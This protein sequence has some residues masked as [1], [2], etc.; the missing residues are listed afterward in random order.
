MEGIDVESITVKDLKITRRDEGYSRGREGYEQILHASL[1]LLVDEG[2]KA[3][4]FRRI[5]KACDMNVGNVTYYFKTKEDLI[6]QLLDAII[7][8]Y[9]DEFLKIM[10]LT[11]RGPERQLE[12]YVTVIINDIATRKTTRV[13]PELW[14]L[15]N[16]DAF[17]AERVQEMYDRARVTINK[18]IT[19]LNPEL[20]DEERETVAL[21]I[22]A[23]M[24]G[25]TVFAGYEKPWAG[26]RAFLKNIAIL[27]FTNLVKT[28]RSKDIQKIRS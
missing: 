25:L 23:S 22:S 3:I 20:S 10:T 1:N 4:S 9:E 14:A 19:E 27:T 17:I 15:A 18:I 28:I 11:K 24:E 8:S 26:N 5:A 12:K 7:S 13:F 21:F 6:R 2:Y 16:H